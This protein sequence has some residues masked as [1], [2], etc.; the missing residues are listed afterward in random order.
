MRKNIKQYSNEII[1][2]YVN[3]KLSTY[4]IAK[5]YSCC[6][7]TI[8]NILKE[9]NIKMRKYSE[10]NRHYEIDEHYFDKINTP[11]KAYILGFL[12][13]DG[14]N[15]PNK[16]SIRLSIKLDDIK[17]LEKMAKVSNNNTP[18]KIEIKITKGKEGKYAGLIWNSTYLSNQLYNKGLVQNKSLILTFP[19]WLDEELISHFIRGYFDGD[20][21]ISLSGNGVQCSVVSTKMFIDDLCKILDEKFNLH[22]TRS[23]ASEKT[24]NKITTVLKICTQKD[25]KIF[26]DWIYKDANIYLE[27]KYERY[28]NNFYKK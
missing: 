15:S 4:Q 5:E 2:L 11:E 20:G 28:Y 1:D 10:S 22:Y 17:I 24:G 9:N 3:K 14:C 19:K 13:A 21:S 8:V 6:Q 23:L 25:V 26:L 7:T 18:I 27:R 12:Y 16:K